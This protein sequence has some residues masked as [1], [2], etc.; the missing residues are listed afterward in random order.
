MKKADNEKA[1]ETD[2][3]AKEKSYELGCSVK[4]NQ[5]QKQGLSMC[6]YHIGFYLQKLPSDTPWLRG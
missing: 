2:Q 4:P 6:S 5:W 1:L 3:Y